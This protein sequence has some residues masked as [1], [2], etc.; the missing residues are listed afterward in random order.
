MVHHTICNV[1]VGNKLQRFLTALACAA[2]CLLSG[3]AA[4][5][6]QSTWTTVGPPGFS[7]SSAASIAVALDAAGNPVV[8]Y[9]DYST[10]PAGRAVVQRYNSATGAWDFLGPA[11][12]I[13]PDASIANDLALDAA[14]NPILLY[15][16]M[17]AMGPG[18][19][20]RYNSATNAWDGIDGG[21]GVWPGD[22][23]L[24]L[25]AAGTPFVAYTEG[26]TSPT[27]RAVVQRYNSAANT[28]EFVGPAA[29]I[30]S[31]GALSPVLAL[32]AAGNPVLAYRDSSVAPIVIVVKRYNGAAGVWQDVGPAGGVAG[33]AALAQQ[34]SLA[35]D[36]AGNPLVAYMDSSTTPANR[37]VVKRYNSAAGAWQEVGPAGGASPAG[38]ANT[39]SLA[40]DAAGN[41]VLA[42]AD[43]TSTPAWRAVVK[44]YNSA[45]GAWDTL[46]AA[47]FASAGQA[48]FY[49]TSLALDAAGNP[50]LGFR[51][52]D[53]AT[54]G[55]IT[56]V[57]FGAPPPP[58]PPPPASSPIPT[59][60]PAALL[61]L[62]TALGLL[63]LAARRHRLK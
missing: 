38:V 6:A 60:N 61:L 10:T 16:S 59:L 28:W 17:A 22:M 7:A 62:A 53:A 41:P 11:A 55:P 8:T 63:A 4:A 13:S 3:V 42:Y 40:L 37:A 44:R 39:V 15:R 2:V 29:G 24:A 48:D 46:G 36:A 47:G 5:Q 35:L 26:T 49:F 52:Y 54:T 50:V 45:T 9:R 57:K 43:A 12:G 14:G 32:D 33:Q 20:K 23:A 58:P 1:A 21:V 25:D 51:D 19:V 27:F 34:I 30:S 18:A 31:G 56:V